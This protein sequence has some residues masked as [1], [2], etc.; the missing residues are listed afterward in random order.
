MKK[1]IAFSIVNVFLFVG[2]IGIN[3]LY[4]VV[5]GKLC[6]NFKSSPCWYVSGGQAT[7]GSTPWWANNY[8]VITCCVNGAD[9]DGCDFSME[10][11]ECEQKVTRNPHTNCSGNEV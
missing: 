6:R 5:D 8:T 3:K 4:A 1:L 2:F 9:I 11:K 7:I 10:N